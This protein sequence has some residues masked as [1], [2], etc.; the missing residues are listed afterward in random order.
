MDKKSESKPE[1]GQAAELLGSWRAAERDTAAAK[2][3][4]KIAS[5]ALAAAHAAE[6]A[7]VE[8]EAA[9]R[10]AAE[11]AKAAAEAVDRA[12]A[13]ASSA[14]RAA[15]AAAEAALLATAVAEGDKARATHQ[16]DVAEKSE[17]VAHDQF[18]EA[19]GRGFTKQGD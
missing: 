18:R 11:A 10:S 16:V 8:T 14:K 7:A 6:E 3:A 17:E 4:V 19:E 1:S 2:T 12:M 5:L 13:A 9:S 15:S